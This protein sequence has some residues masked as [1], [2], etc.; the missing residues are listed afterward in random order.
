[1]CLIT[2]S[3]PR[4]DERVVDRGSDLS[5]MAQRPVNLLCTRATSYEHNCSFHIFKMHHCVSLSAATMPG[6]LMLDRRRLDSA[7]G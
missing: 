5:S 6:K 2:F 1:M 7:I 4:P 3:D